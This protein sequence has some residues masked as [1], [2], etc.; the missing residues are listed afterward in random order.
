V[1]VVVQGVAGEDAQERSTH[2]SLPWSERTASE[3]K[4]RAGSG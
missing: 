2:Q 4:G 1:R 3:E